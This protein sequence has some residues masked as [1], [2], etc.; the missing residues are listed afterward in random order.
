MNALLLA[1]GYGTRLRPLT[2][3][4]PKCLVPIKNR[5]LLDIWIESLVSLGINSI[6]INTHYLSDIVE[7]HIN[8][9]IYTNQIDLV[10]EN[11]LLGTGGTLI[12]NIDFFGGED[13]LM[14]HADNYC[15]D[16]LSLLITAHNNRPNGC[17]ITILVF[18]TENPSSCGIVEINS[19]GIVTGFFEK[20]NNPPGNLANG[21]I[22]LL[23][24]EAI[25]II[26]KGYSDKSDF[27]TE[28]LVQ[29]VGKIFTYKTDKIFID[30]GTPE[31]YNKANSI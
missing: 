27:V 17:L 13:G 2:N 10:Y 5:P 26:K 30:I 20:I 16:D 12:N 24:K 8:K 22:Y 25:D 3:L 18:E 1:A 29:F 21:A 9:S 23:S 7:E 4:I 11:D 15:L 19:L 28:I 6:R 31:A 14:I